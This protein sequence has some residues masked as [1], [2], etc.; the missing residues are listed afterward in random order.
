MQGAVS[1]RTL[2]LR[3]RLATA[4]PPVCAVLQVS[5]LL[6]ELILEAVRIGAL[7]IRNRLHC[8]LRDLLVA[9]L[10][11]ASSMPTDIVLP[12]ERRARAVAQLIIETPARRSTL[13]TLCAEVGA[14]L[15]TVERAFRR[16]VAPI[17]NLGGGVSG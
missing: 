10:M 5:P 7:R 16:D 14:S 3:D 1:M 9:Q 11:S 4:T 13:G 6:R 17:R 15:R 2:Y 12:S 8:A